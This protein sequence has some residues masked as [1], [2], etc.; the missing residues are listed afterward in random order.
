MEPG[1]R[2]TKSSEESSP[3]VGHRETGMGFAALAFSTGASGDQERDRIRWRLVLTRGLMMS[4][5]ILLLLPAPITGAV[6]GGGVLVSAV[7]ASQPSGRGAD[8]ADRR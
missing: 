6:G 2:S 3:A 8:G 4:P 5:M 1:A 7:D